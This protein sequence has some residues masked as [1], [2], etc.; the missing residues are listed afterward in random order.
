MMIDYWYVKTN[1]NNY[2]KPL[3]GFKNLFAIGTCTRTT[4]TA[5]PADQACCDSD[6][7]SGLAAAK[8]SN[9]KDFPQSAGLEPARG[10]PN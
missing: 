10:D 7:A 1:L 4:L 8:K 6:C 2:G 5:D 9:Q 3:F